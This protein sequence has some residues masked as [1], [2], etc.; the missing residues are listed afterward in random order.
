VEVRLRPL[1]ADDVPVVA[2]LNDAEVPRVGHLGVE[3]LRAHLPRCAPALLA[4]DTD[5]R[6]AGFVLAVPPG[7]DY[8]S[9]NYRWFEARGS[10]HLYVDRVVVADHARRRGVGGRL[11]GAVEDAARRDGRTEVTCEVNLRPRNDASLAFHAA[12][13]YVEVGREDVEAGTKTVAM[14]AKPVG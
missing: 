11:Y 4:E 12:R 8:A 14:L 3:G 7:V 5:G 1:V 2:A 6:V 13:G 9:V 10:D